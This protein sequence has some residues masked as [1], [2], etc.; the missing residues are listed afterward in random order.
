MNTI[1]NT[2]QQPSTTFQQPHTSPPPQ[3][4]QPPP[5]QPMQRGNN[6]LVVTKTRKKS[7]VPLVIVLSLSFLLIGGSILYFVLKDED[8]S[9]PF[10]DT[11][12]SGSENIQVQFKQDN[13][14]DVYDQDGVYVAAGYWNVTKTFEDDLTSGVIVL[15]FQNPGNPNDVEEPASFYYHVSENMFVIH[16]LDD[17][18]DG[19]DPMVRSSVGA[20]E[21]M[22]RVEVAMAEPPNFCTLRDVE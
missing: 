16:A 4:H 10:E 3:T 1:Q 15:T 17:N 13:T 21:D 6:L 19:C 11:W 20:T 8:L 18:G 9:Y 12:I 14:Y 7:L 22:R 5:L 2:A